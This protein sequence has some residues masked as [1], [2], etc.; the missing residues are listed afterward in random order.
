MFL[1][2]GPKML[3]DLLTVD[4]SGGLFK[5]LVREGMA[6]QRGGCKR[7]GEQNS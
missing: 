1:K 4:R 6:Y 3:H 2:G 7:E 5:T